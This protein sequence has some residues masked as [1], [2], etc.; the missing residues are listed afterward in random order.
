MD[1]AKSEAVEHELDAMI[2]RRFSSRRQDEE[3]AW[4]EDAWAD[5]VR[6]H[7]ARRREALC[8]EWLRWHQRMLNN[9][10]KTAAL[11]TAHHRGE[12]ERYER[13]LSIDHE[14]EGAA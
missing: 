3:P 8:W 12:I 11:I 6:K 9:H 4:V 5:S 10:T 13:L 7:N 1:I 14:G 2:R